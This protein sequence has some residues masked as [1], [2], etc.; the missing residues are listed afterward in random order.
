MADFMADL[1]AKGA[2]EC[3]EVRK[4]LEDEA[5]FDEEILAIG[6]RALSAFGRD[7]SRDRAPDPSRP[8]PS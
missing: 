5:D 3:S 8:G 2:H 1:A 4:E 7:L 6:R